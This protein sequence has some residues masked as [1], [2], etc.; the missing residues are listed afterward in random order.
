MWA[1]CSSTAGYVDQKIYHKPFGRRSICPRNAC[2]KAWNWWPAYLVYW[3]HV[4]FSLIA[5]YATCWYYVAEFK[6]QDTFC[7]TIRLAMTGWNRMHARVLAL[8]L[9]QRNALALLAERAAGC[10][11]FVPDIFC[12]LWFVCL[13]ATLPL[14][15]KVSL[16]E[17]L[18]SW[19]YQIIL[20]RSVQ[21]VSQ[22]V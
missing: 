22:T 1:S 11:V 4:S 19:E 9:M 5:H 6:F 15:L 18:A 10:F 17:M 16:S 7:W 13:Y 20:H 2:R 12:L 8:Q 21:Q 3:K 14:H